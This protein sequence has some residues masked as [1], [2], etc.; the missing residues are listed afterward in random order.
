M[1]IL[2]SFAAVLAVVAAKPSVYGENVLPL[3]V[4]AGPVHVPAVVSSSFRKD[5]IHKPTVTSYTAPA[6]IGHRAVVDSVP[7]P[8]VEKTFVQPAPIVEKTIVQPPPIVEKTVI[9]PES[10]AH[11]YRKDVI[12]KPVISIHTPEVVAPVV[13]P[14]VEKTIV[15]P[16]PVVHRTLVQPALTHAYSGYVSHNPIPLNPLGVAPHYR[17][18]YYW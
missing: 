3:S 14:L 17:R 12:G 15:Q 9:Q 10:I 6:V 16:A 8:I 7:L 18:N 13:A 11:T 5:V 4:P 2:V 1:F